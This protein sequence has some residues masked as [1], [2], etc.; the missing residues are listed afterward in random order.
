MRRASTHIGTHKATLPNSVSQLWLAITTVALLFIYALIYAP[1]VSAETTAEPAIA[2]SQ[3]MVVYKSPSCG[4]CGAWVDHMNAAGFI[5]TV[6]H[7][8][9]LNAI[10]QTLGVAPAYQACHT[11]TWK[12]YVFEGHIPADV[13]QHFLANKPRNAAGLAVAGMPM[14]SPGMETNKPYRAYQ[15]VQLNQDGSSTSYATVSASN[16]FYV[17]EK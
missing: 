12:N 9:D 5:T 4:C 3:S 6:Q 14:G 1:M 2:T 15:V 7:P 16:T 11:A 13:I 17:G 10:K 8:N